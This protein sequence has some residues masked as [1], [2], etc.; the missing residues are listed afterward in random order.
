[1]GCA[2][3]Q[4]IKNKAEEC[5]EEANGLSVKYNEGLKSML[6]QLKLE[7]KSINYSYF[8]TYSVLQNIIQKPAAYGTSQKL[9]WLRY[10]LAYRF[11]IC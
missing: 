8:D 2:P 1:M 3:S 9:A 6:L 4:R 10:K 7:L 11:Y 5:N